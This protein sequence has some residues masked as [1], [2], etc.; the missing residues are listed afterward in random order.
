MSASSSGGLFIFSLFMHL[1]Y[2]LPLPLSPIQ[3]F[4]IVKTDLVIG[5]SG[6]SGYNIGQVVLIPVVILTNV[7]DEESDFP[8]H[9]AGKRVGCFTRRR[10]NFTIECY[11][12]AQ[13]VQPRG[14]NKKT[15]KKRQTTAATIMPNTNKNHKIITS[16]GATQPG[17]DGDIYLSKRFLKL[18]KHL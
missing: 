4:L 14:S 7:V 8:C 1:V 6:R 9:Y 15:V 3:I 5:H 13:V 11:I 16:S 2:Y 12:E 10:L 18:G 17:Y